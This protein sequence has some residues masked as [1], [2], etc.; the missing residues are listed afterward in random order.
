MIIA[1]SMSFLVLFYYCNTVMEYKQSRFKS[2]CIMIA[3]Y[4]IY[5]AISMCRNTMIILISGFF[6]QCAI[7]YLGYKTGWGKSIFQS[8]V[9][10]V[11]V[12]FGELIASVIINMEIGYDNHIVSYTKDIAFTLISKIIYF[13]LVT[14]FAH[15][16][17]NKSN[18]YH[19]KEMLYLIIFPI[20]VCLFLFIF[21]QL[22]GNVNNII[23]TLL[24]ICGVMLIISTV[25]VYIVCE[26]IVSKNIEIQYLQSLSHKKEIDNKSYQLMK[27][28]YNELKIMTHDFNKYCNS[29][30][31]L[32]NKEQDE[33]LHMTQAIKSKSK[34]FLLVEYTNNT[35]L[36]ILLSQKMKE[37]NDENIDFRLYVKDIDL[38]FIRE[39]DIVAIFANLI[40]NAMESCMNSA[41]RKIFLS[42]NIMNDSYIVIRIDNSA[43][44]E[45]VIINNHLTT[46]KKDKENHGIGFLSIQKALE[47]YNGSLRWNYDS[48]T[49]AFT[50]TILINIFKNP[51]T[52]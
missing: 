52:N 40:D 35:A 4:I 13:F 6:I 38:S 22:Y 16:S 27:E 31:G 50:T 24:I 23:K 1:Y 21:S 15:T 48:D 44:N 10:T 30:E 42:I 39:L 2:I 49:H 26:H 46:W 51:I 18:K 29:I 12:M 32:L 5:Y 33:A 36:N 34:E 7:M 3:G 37:C 9:L 20:T 8:A 17:T 14:V 45:P 28:K 47:K 41:Q 19:S 11:L 25:I 43:D